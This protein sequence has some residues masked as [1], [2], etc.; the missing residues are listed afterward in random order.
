MLVKFLGRALALPYTLAYRALYVFRFVFGADDLEMFRL[1]QKAL[2]EG[3]AI[4]G[5]WWP[6]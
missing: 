6:S 3:T 5:N 1:K 2:S 4:P